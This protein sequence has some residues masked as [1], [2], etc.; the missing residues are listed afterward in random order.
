MQKANK[1][2]ST[3]EAIRR[4]ISGALW[5]LALVIA[6]ANILTANIFSDIREYLYLFEFATLVI[7]MAVSPKVSFNTAL[8]L[9]ITMF[10]LSTAIN[11]PAPYFRSWERLAFFTMMLSLISPLI[12]NNMLKNFR[13]DLWH[14]LILI[15]KIEMIVEFIFYF[16]WLIEN[17]GNHKGYIGLFSHHMLHGIMAAIGTTVFLWEIV[18]R[19]YSRLWI[20]IALFVL[21]FVILVSS[22][23]RCALLGFAAAA[24]PLI[25]NL[26]KQRRLFYGFC[27]S[28]VLLLS[29]IVFIPNPVTKT[30]R[31]KFNLGEKNNSWTFS[32]DE[33]WQARWNEFTDKPVVGIGFC[34]N[35]Y[36]SRSFD[37]PD[38][39]GNVVSEPGS[40]WLS[41]LSN[42]GILSFA[43]FAW[44]NIAL[45]RKLF[46]RFNDDK[47]GLPCG[48]KR[49]RRRS[50]V[51]RLWL[52]LSPRARLL[53]SKSGCGQQPLLYL[54][55]WLLFI[56]H[57]V[58]EGWILYAGSLTFV[59]YWLLTSQITNLPPCNN[60]KR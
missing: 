11:D 58:F 36:C 19:K 22:G 2:T 23:S 50:T 37:S 15:I 18:T 39:E 8:L 40:A 3:I 57:G 60:P 54:S 7:C 21:S 41:I 27:V 13:F 55:L 42:G 30:L 6:L 59:F 49:R 38:E 31:F 26:R 52:L 16:P 12:E 45:L 53:A 48:R 28:A 43:I 1:A 34:T 10:C 47:S 33:L 24:I 4:R 46:G 14:W 5:L 20:G 35:I 32:R 9:L 51:S 56:V 29:A 44:F 25:W 17:Y